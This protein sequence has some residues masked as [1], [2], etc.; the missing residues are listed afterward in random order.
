MISNQTVDRGFAP[1]HGL[2]KKEVIHREEF[3]WEQVCDG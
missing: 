3:E 2:V 1:V